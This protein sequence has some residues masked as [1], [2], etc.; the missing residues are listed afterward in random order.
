MYASMSSSPEREGGEATLDGG[1]AALEGSSDMARLD[2]DASE[3]AERARFVPRRVGVDGELL[4]ECS[5]EAAGDGR[6]F[7][8]EEKRERKGVCVT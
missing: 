8:R 2:E 3:D 6:L 1:S 7:I 5:T 4:G